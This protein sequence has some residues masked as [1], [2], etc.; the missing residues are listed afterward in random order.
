MFDRDFLMLNGEN[1][2]RLLFLLIRNMV[3]RGEQF[4]PYKKLLFARTLLLQNN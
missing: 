3:I 4:I 2:S 1:A